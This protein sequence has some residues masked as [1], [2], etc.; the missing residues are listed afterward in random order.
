MP[1]HL[2]SI[3]EPSKSS[4]S[5]GIWPTTPFVDPAFRTILPIPI[6]ISTPTPSL[7][8]SRGSRWA[9][10]YDLFNNGK[11]SF[12]LYPGKR[13]CINT[14]VILEI[15]EGY[16]GRICPRSGLANKHGIDVLA[17]VIDSDYRGEIKVILIN[18]GEDRFCTGPGDKI[19]QIIF[20]KYEEVQFNIV[21]KLN[22]TERGSGGFGS[23]GS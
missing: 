8:P 6:G 3:Y 12:W 23:T 9:A 4:T 20:Q 16:Y 5:D 2:R 13:V 11:D 15:P 7:I 19:A 18:F 10:G 22:D 21:E 1:E 14:G 17:G